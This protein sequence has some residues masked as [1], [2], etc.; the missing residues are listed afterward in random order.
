MTIYELQQQKR[1]LFALKHFLPPLSNGDHLTLTEFERRYEARPDIKKAE[2]IEGVVYVASPVSLLHAE[3]HGR[4][5]TLIGVYS[6]QTLGL[7]SADN[8]SLVLD[9]DNEVQPDVC[10]W[11]DREEMRP[12][13]RNYLSGVPELVVEVAVS[14]AAYDLYE[15]KHVYRR[16][17]VQEYL[18][19]LAQERELQWLSLH[20]GSYVALE[21]DAAGVIRSQVFPGLALSPAL[22]WANEFAKL[23]TLLQTEMTTPAYEAFRQRAS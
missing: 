7:R 15:K 16:N 9:A 3:I 8:V 20:E 11:R 5:M 6:G 13:A 22:F 14:S 12:T 18:L 21:A 23:L 10:M 2:L 1:S 17:G 4:I 19:L